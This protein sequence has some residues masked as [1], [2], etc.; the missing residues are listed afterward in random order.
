MTKLTISILGAVVLAGSGVAQE[1]VVNARMGGY[2]YNSPYNR[3]YNQNT[4]I[5]FSGRVTGITRTIPMTGTTEGTSLLVKAKTGGTTTVDLGPSWYVQNQHTKI[6]VGDQVQVTG[7]KV[8]VDGH[9][10]IL[11]KLVKKHVDVLALRRPNGRPYWDIGAPVAAV[12]PDPNVTEITGT[13][14]HMVSIGTGPNIA[15]GVV[16][17]TDNGYTTIDLG[18]NWFYQPQGFV[19][20]PGSNLTVMTRGTFNLNSNGTPVPAYWLQY[21]NYWYQFR[22]TNGTG[23]WEVNP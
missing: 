9:G 13:V 11:A 7:S 10:V 8:M 17:Q 22:N 21:N 6:K 4:Q 1:V 15:S 19:F 2:A 5:T 23:M 14:D 16:L 20:T 18:P 12:T 3:L